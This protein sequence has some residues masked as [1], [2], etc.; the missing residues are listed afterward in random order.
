MTQTLPS[1]T[2]TVDPAWIDAYGHLNAA[3]YVGIFDRVGFELLSQVGVGLDYTEAT[4]CGIYTMNVHVAYLR[5]VLEGDPLALRVRVLEADDKR[6]LCLM[7]LTQTRDGYLAATMEQL[8]LHVDLNTR[9]A[10]PFPPEL[11]ERLARAAADHAAQPL[12]EGYRRLL[13]LKGAR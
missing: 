4:R 7:E 8:S 11:Q 9:R 2:L 1:T 10:K 5:E 3:H 13:P 6:L 12:P